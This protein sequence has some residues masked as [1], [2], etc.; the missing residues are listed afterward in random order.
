MGKIPRNQLSL[1][2]RQTLTPTVTATAEIEAAGCSNE[3]QNKEPVEKRSYVSTSTTNIRKAIAAMK[4][5]SS[6]T[7]RE[8]REKYNV[9]LSTL[10]RGY[11]TGTGGPYVLQS[12]LYYEHLLE[13]TGGG[14]RKVTRVEVSSCK[15]IFRRTSKLHTLF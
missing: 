13:K 11:K 6:F 4:A 14:K 2:K 3:V 12:D 1:M 10:S 7:Y 5:D 15:D 9:A 8:A